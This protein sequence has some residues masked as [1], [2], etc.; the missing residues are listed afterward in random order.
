MFKTE[1]DTVSCEAVFYLVSD[2]NELV[3]IRL[4]VVTTTCNLFGKGFK[5]SCSNRACYNYM[6]SS[7]YETMYSS[8]TF[9]KLTV[10]SVIKG[11]M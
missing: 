9:D 11:L 4:L 2:I 7:K 6:N 3:Q 1:L 10:S 5:L 8:Y